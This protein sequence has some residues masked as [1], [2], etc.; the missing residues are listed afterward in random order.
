MHVLLGVF[1]L[2]VAAMKITR[3][4]QLEKWQ[5]SVGLL[6]LAVVLH[7]VS[8]TLTQ[9]FIKKHAP[10]FA[11]TNEVI[12]GVQA[13]ELTTGL[14]IVPKWVSCI[15]LLAISALVTAVWPWVIGVMKLLF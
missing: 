8:A 15:G 1:V 14:G 6:F 9:L 2:S 13:W 12:P 10:D 7:L 5:V 3:Y 4:F 11:S